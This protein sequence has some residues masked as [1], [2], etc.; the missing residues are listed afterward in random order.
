MIIPINLKENSYTILIERGALQKAKELFCLDRKVLIV[1]DDGV[2]AEYAKTVAAAAKEPYVETVP[3]GEESKSFPV[4]EHLLRKMLSLGFS[5]KDCVVAVGGGVV[6]DLVGFTAASY[7][8]GID[9]YTV[10]TTVLSAVDASIGGKTALNLDGIKNIVGS[11]YQ[12]GAVLIDPDTMKTLSKRQ[13]SNGLAEALKMSLTSDP[14]LFRI[15]AEQDPFS[16][17]DEIIARS[18]M[19]KKDVVEQDEKEQ[20]LRKVL[21]FGHTIG[22]GIESAGHVLGLYHGECVAIGMIPMCSEKVRKELLSVLRKL[23]LPVFAPIDSEEVYK[24]LLHDKKATGD[25]VSAVTVDE[26]GSFS[27]RA[28]PISSLRPLIDTVTGQEIIE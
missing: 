6:S 19:I 15:F 7:M 21:N 10:P 11:F 2:P 3:Q 13:V 9:Y 8:R 12:P 4:F 28:V 27:I 20:G 23:E 22:H 24:A 17:L 25:E 1:T 5:R 18:I 16:S 14:K 26:I